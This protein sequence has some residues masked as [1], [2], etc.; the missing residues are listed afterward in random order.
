M[1][2]DNRKIV[3]YDVSRFNAVK[4]GIL[5]KETLLPHENVEDYQALL[6]ALESEYTPEG[7]SE[8]TLVEELAGILWRKRRLLL[9]EGAKI[10]EGINSQMAYPVRVVNT[11]VPFSLHVSG[12]EYTEGEIAI[13]DLMKLTDDEVRERQN[14]LLSARQQI[15]SAHNRLKVAGRGAAKEALNLLPD[16]AE[17]LWYSEDRS[18]TIYEVEEFINNELLPYLDREESLLSCIS[19]MRRQILGNA[20]IQLPF[21]SLTRYEAH[22]DRKF[23]RTLSIL[24]KLKSLKNMSSESSSMPEDKA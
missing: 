3:G 23:E 10:N 18:E 15:I 8:Q 5:S 20:V 17:D 24:L 7:I 2:G 22:L 16:I 12:S 13:R 1:C 14:Q 9:A 21:D 6:S 11:A 19:S 4:H